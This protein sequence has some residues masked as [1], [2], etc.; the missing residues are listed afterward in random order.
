MA[1][2][3]E[4]GLGEG[5]GAMDVKRIVTA[6]LVGLALAG[7]AHAQTVSDGV[8][9][10]T[11]TGQAQAWTGIDSVG[12]I[13]SQTNPLPTQLNPGS[14]DR[15]FVLIQPS[16]LSAVFQR[17]IATQ[18]GGTNLRADSSTAVDVR[19]YWQ[20][21]LMIYPTFIN[22]DG[23]GADSCAGALYAMQARAH[24]AAQT[25]SQSTFSTLPHIKTATL[26]QPDSIGSMAHI[27][28]GTFNPTNAAVDTTVMPNETALVIANVGNNPRGILV[29]LNNRDGS[30]ITGDYLSLRLR[31]IHSFARAGYV[32]TPA[33]VVNLEDAA[34]GALTS[35]AQRV[36]LRVDLVGRR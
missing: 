4:Q 32:G 36:R 14:L 33:A 22:S 27:A 9:R 16:L 25:D 30:P 6:A 28:L 13:V 11:M 1:Q 35:W 3:A 31:A 17:V 19:G 26:F 29:Y 20:L 34:G 8:K 24:Y 7:A 18:S 15:N 10:T 23:T 5:L 12:H 2:T 21:A